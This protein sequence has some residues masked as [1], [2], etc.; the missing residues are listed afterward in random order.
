[1]S[2]GQRSIVAVRWDTLR[3]QKRGNL[4]I[5]EVENYDE[6]NAD[7]VESEDDTQENP[8]RTAREKPCVASTRISEQE[9]ETPV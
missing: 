3:K 9:C 5:G 1:M 8:H 6:K 4:R 2:I 7:E